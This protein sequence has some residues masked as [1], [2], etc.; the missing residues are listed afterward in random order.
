MIGFVEGAQLAVDAGAQEALAGELL[1]VLPVLALAAAHDGGQDHDAL[2][3]RSAMTCW[4]IC[5]V[6]WQAISWPQ[7]GQCGTPMEEYSRRR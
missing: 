1:E 6:D 3:G 4:R 2:V 5:S 7:L